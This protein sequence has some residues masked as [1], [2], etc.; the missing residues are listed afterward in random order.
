MYPVVLASGVQFASSVTADHTQEILLQ[1]QF[2][3]LQVVGTLP[4][5]KSSLLQEFR[6]PYLLQMFKP[7]AVHLV[8]CTAGV[9]TILLTAGVQAACCV[10]RLIKSRLI[11]CRCPAHEP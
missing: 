6:Q 10:S 3:S 9:Q 2:T 7:L 8:S 11:D 4:C 1:F 5:I